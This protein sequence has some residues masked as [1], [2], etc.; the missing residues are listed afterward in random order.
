MNYTYIVELVQYSNDS[1][2]LLGKFDTIYNAYDYIEQYSLMSGYKIIMNY[3][4][5]SDDQNR[6]SIIS[7]NNIKKATKYIYIRSE[8]KKNKK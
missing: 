6:G 3:S 1:I 4:D 2:E 8:I 5:L 7:V